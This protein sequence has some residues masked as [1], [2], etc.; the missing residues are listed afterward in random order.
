MA[1]IVKVG[2]SYKAQV[3]LFKN[4]QQKRLTKTFL[5][6]REAEIWGLQQEIDKGQ[7]CELGGREIPFVEFYENWLHTVKEGHIRAN[8]FKGYIWALKHIKRM[9]GQT[10]LKDLNDIMIQRKLDEFGKTHSKKSVSLLLVKLRTVLKDAQA[11]GYLANNF[12]PLLKSRGKELPK[13]NRALSI[14][15][16]KQ[17]K[18]Y[19]MQH[20][21]DEFCIMA[22]LALE[23]GMRKCEIL[24]L[25]P[26]DLYKYGVHVRRSRHKNTEETS[27]K[28][29]QSKRDI[30]INSEIYYLLQ[31]VSA[32]DDGYLFDKK[33]FCTVRELDSLFKKLGI[34]KTTFHGLRDTHASFLFSQNIDLMYVSKRLGHSNIQTTQNFY[35][36]LM[37]EKKHEQDDEALRLLSSL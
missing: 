6:K 4:G 2:N 18:A 31:T 35:L 26:D 16:L 9:F 27:L 3:S 29:P 28:T 37:P 11:R 24:G 10:K 5:T 33:Y 19:L 21:D 25:R 14:K 1:S 23:T 15:E 20:T 17:L 12:L 22:L 8:T 36:E 13:R 34:E 32:K 30:S 7:G